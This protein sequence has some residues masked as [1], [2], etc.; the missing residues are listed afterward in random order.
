MV[1]HA[2]TK[3]TWCEGVG[4]KSHSSSTSNALFALFAF[5]R[6]N[7]LAKRLPPKAGKRVA[8]QCGESPCAAALQPLYPLYPLLGGTSSRF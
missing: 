1:E 5:P 6:P 3:N 2:G 8:K 7:A 4:E